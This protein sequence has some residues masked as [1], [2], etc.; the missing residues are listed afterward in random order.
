MI[1]KERIGILDRA[2]K[3]GLL[4]LEHIHKLP[5]ILQA[6]MV[7]LIELGKYTPVDG[8]DSKDFTAHIVASCDDIQQLQ[9]GTFNQKLYEL[10]SYN[11]IK[12]PPLRE[13]KDDIIP[14]ANAIVQ[15][16]CIKKHIAEVP[17][18]DVSAQIK[19]YTHSWPGNYR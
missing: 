14:T 3:K 5:P 2:N 12:I 15:D 10:L 11:I 6:A 9:D 4:Y 16:Y 19:L 13:S 18:F 17:E 8:M 1:K 7:K